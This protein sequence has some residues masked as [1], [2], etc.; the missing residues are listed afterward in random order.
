MDFKAIADAFSSM[1]CIISVEKKL[2]GDKRA[3]RIVTGND[4]YIRSI[5]HPAPNLILWQGTMR[6]K[7]QSS[8]TSLVPLATFLVLVNTSVH[9]I[10]CY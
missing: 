8:L 9:V 5:E 2:T 10:Y 6:A 4:A 7:C 1:A 3:F